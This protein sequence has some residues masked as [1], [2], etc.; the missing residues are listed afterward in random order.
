VETLQADRGPSK[1]CAILCG[2]GS[3]IATYGALTSIG[4]ASEVA[5]ASAIGAVLGFCSLR[6]WDRMRRPV[7]AFAGDVVRWRRWP[8]P[9]SVVEWSDVRYVQFAVER[10]W[11]GV[12]SQT[13][14]IYPTTGKP[15]RLPAA[16]SIE[17]VLGL[18]PR[19][20]IDDLGERARRA[21]AD[22]SWLQLPKTPLR[23]SVVRP[24]ERR[25]VANAPRRRA[26]AALIAAVWVFFSVVLTGLGQ[27]L[28]PGRV[29]AALCVGLVFALLVLQGRWVVD[30]DVLRG[31][32]RARLALA[33][34]TDASVSRGR[35]GHAFLQIEGPVD[36]VRIPVAWLPLRIEHFLRDIGLQ[37]SQRF[38]SE[39]TLGE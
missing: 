16:L 38:A 36:K 9:D 11:T 4:K 13:L 34:A 31:P 10:G 5:S 7:L 23:R 37:P 8:L 20:S 21:G 32:M 22:V 24:F 1:W 14:T 30:G 12:G 17:P 26:Q 39:R 29:L 27:A 3:L 25:V 6:A 15:R 28:T 2:I 18:G 35:D 19:G 33:Q